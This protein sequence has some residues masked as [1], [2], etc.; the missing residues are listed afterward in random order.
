MHAIENNYRTIII[1][2]ACRGVNENNIERK[3]AELREIGCIL[4][5]S[6]VVRKSFFIALFNFIFVQLLIQ[7]AGMVA[8]E[9][10]RPEIAHSMFIENLKTISHHHPR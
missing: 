7:V 6:D 4:V 1:E 10:R 5:D 9:D 2:D 3:R 8:G